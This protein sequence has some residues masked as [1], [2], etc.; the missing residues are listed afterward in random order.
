M[1]WALHGNLGHPGDW[2]FLKSRVPAP[3][4]ARQLWAEVADYESWAERFCAEVAE[5]DEAPVLLGYSMGG[6]L[7]LHA[8]LHRPGLWRAAVVVSAHTGLADRALRLARHAQDREW[9]QKVRELPWDVMT[10]AWNAQPVFAGS[11]GALPKRDLLEWRRAIMQSF[12]CWGLSRQ[13]DLLPRLGEVRCPVLWVA[14]GRDERYESLGR[15]AVKAL[16][17][18]ELSVIESCGHR[19]PWEAPE[20]F[21]GLVGDFL[22]RVA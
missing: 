16:P 22:G 4:E 6:R 14:G 11:E 21:A 13:N 17:A 19:V 12:T 5:R 10:K 7:A 15:A 20:E 2:D 18:G 9:A 8:L 1:I 3:V